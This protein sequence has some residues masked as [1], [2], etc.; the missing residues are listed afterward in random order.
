V[1]G[2]V[3]NRVDMRRDDTYS[4]YSGYNY[5][6]AQRPENGDGKA[7]KRVVGRAVPQQAAHD[8]GGTDGGTENY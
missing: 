7:Q 3:L 4:Y 8:V 5:Y 2:V 1:V 6:Y